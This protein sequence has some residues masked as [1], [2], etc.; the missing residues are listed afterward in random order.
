MTFQHDAG[1]EDDNETDQLTASPARKRVAVGRLR[2]TRMND[3]DDEENV[4]EIGWR[5]DGFEAEFGGFD[6][7][8]DEFD[9]CALV[10]RR[11]LRPW[12]RRQGQ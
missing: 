6:K 2:S 10:T 5:A 1:T 4:V 8:L 11:W 3:D 9:H 12:P 7:P